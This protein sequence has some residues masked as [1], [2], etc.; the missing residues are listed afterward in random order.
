MLLDHQC[1]ARIKDR[2]KQLP[3]HRA[4]AIGSDVIILILLEKGKSPINATD[5]DGATALHHAMAEGHG[6]TAMF[7]LRR[8]AESHKRDS[9]GRLAI[10][11]AADQEVSFFPTLDAALLA[12]VSKH[13]LKT[14]CTVLYR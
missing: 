14:E 7:L 11:V 8:E 1:S 2:R 5:L 6:E 13:W 3:I 12:C 4:A 10:D 9:D